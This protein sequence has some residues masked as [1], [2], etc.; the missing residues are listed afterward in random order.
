MISTY[1]RFHLT[2]KSYNYPFEYDIFFKNP[3]AG[4]KHLLFFQLLLNN[5]LSS[6]V[7]DLALKGLGL[8]LSNG[9]L[10]KGKI[11]PYD[12]NEVLILPSFLITRIGSDDLIEY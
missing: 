12:I 1:S 2:K 5:F 3:L 11:K 4:I 10:A 6:T 8:S 9:F 7:F